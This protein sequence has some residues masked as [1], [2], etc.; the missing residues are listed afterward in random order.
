M[1][2]SIIYF[3]FQWGWNNSKMCLVVAQLEHFAW[4]LWISWK[5][6][7]KWTTKALKHVWKWMSDHEDTLIFKNLFF[8]VYLFLQKIFLICLKEVMTIFW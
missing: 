1:F 4:P 6:D 3:E 7:C 2:C 5:S 8:F